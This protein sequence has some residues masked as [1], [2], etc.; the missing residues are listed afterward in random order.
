M[1]DKFPPSGP[2][3]TQQ[4]NSTS[5]TGPPLSEVVWDL[6]RSTPLGTLKAMIR[7]RVS[8]SVQAG[9][10]VQAMVVSANAGVPPIIE[11][12][13]GESGGEKSFQMI[14]VRVVSDARHYWLPEPQNPEDPVAGFY[15]V[16]KHDLSKTNGNTLQWGQFVIIRHNSQAT[17]KWG[18]LSVSY[19]LRICPNTKHLTRTKQKWAL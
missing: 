5:T 4:L 17:W 7:E 12:V 18:I 1:S 2:V 8:P 19:P 3:V 6:D 9:L 10:R 13:Y 15:P 16:I 11:T 14:R